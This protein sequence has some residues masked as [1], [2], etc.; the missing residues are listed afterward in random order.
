MNYTSPGRKSRQTRKPTRILIMFLMAVAS[1]TVIYLFVIRPGASETDQSESS[2][3]S[4]P[5]EVSTPAYTP[6]DLQSTIDTWDANQPANYGI[7]IYDL[8][9]KTIIGSVQQDQEFFA[10]SLYKQYVAYLALLD[11]QNG[12]M[13]PDEILSGSYTRKECIEKMIR[14]SHSPCGEAM[15]ADMGQTTLNQRVAAMGIKGTFFNGIRT[16]AHDSA[17]ILQY[18]AEGR[19]LNTENSAFLRDAMLTQEAKYKRGLQT[20]AP[21]AKWETKVGWNED[22]NYHDIG[23]MT[24]PDGRAFVV[25]I[26]GQGSGSSVPIADFAQTIYT[27]LTQ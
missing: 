24:L 5:E 18:L 25:A 19:D 4:E 16:T 11:I 17:L 8:Q 9:S 10:A 3:V 12:D 1:L 14:E 21:D 2:Q 22:I 13:N 23:I 6:I 7:V 26:L 27:A 20:G 15:M